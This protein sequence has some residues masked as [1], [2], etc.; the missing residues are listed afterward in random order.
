MT[1]NFDFQSHLF[2]AIWETN[3]RVGPQISDSAFFPSSDHLELDDKEA[4]QL[5]RDIA[6]AKPRLF[7]FAG[8][9]PLQRSRIYSL[10]QYAASC[11]L[12]PHMVLGPS[13][14]VTRASMMELKKTNLSRLGLTL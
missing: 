4:E 6:D 14:K 1:T 9:D 13:S 3:A 8:F 5:I 11:G 12:R 10:V 2:V 7:V